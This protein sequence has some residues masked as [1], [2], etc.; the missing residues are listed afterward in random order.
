MTNDVL[1]G[2][3]D[4]ENIK[5]VA[6]D[7]NTKNHLYQSEIKIL[8][9]QIQCLRDK[10]FGK[11]TEK[12][13]RDDGQLSLFDIPE[14]ECPLLEDPVETK[15]TSHTRKKKGRK[16]LPANL[17]RIEV[18]HELSEEERQC[19]CGCLKTYSGQE[20]SEQLDF[21]P[22]KVQV[23]Q[24]I[25][26]KYACKNC[27]GVEDDGPTISIARMPE[28]MIPKSMATPGLLA[29]ILTAKFADALPF[30][31][32][33]K[34]FSRIGVELPRSTMC[35]WAMKVAQACEILM[36]FMQAQILQGGMINIDETTVQVLKVP[37]RSKCY[38]WVFKGGTP[39]KPIILFQYHPTR[40]GDVAL[41][42]L[43]GYQGIVQTDGYSGYNFL[44]TM[45]GI[46]HVACWVHARRKFTDVIKAL[47]RKKGTPPS[48]N[49][50]TALK[51]ISKLYK[52]EKQAKEKGLS[53]E[54]I[55]KERQE[56]A[57]PLLEE[58][59]KWLDVKIEQAPPKSLLGKAIG[60]TLNQW[61]RLICYTEDGRIYPDN[62]VVE[63]AIRPFV[64]GR[65]NWLFSNTPEGAS[66]SACIYSLI[67]TAKANGLE[68]Y[69]YLKYL[70]E[71][72]PEAMTA[73]EFKALM[74][75]N[76]DKNLLAGPVA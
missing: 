66:A 10:L 62:N 22:A 73:D 7:L 26:Y 1:S 74:P 55:Y 58:F 52:I 75:H 21:I 59:K 4:L 44:D 50:G 41:Q 69:W 6:I 48:G 29:H 56:K 38:M 5:K 2:I 34:Q 12:I 28:Q 46:I 60:Y 8:N 15:V 25:R 68:P 30:Y 51:Y 70:F 24:N 42:F 61:H 18:I 72:L 17:P 39:D 63:N 33:E 19:G 35:N 54:E 36:G 14:P 71:N 45:I 47:G 27:E 20:V 53:P 23:I 13:S 32:Q 65:K 9:E 37:K 3:T 57:V 16:P 64:I 40:S 31:R 49:A 76:I 11:K 43:D 67:E